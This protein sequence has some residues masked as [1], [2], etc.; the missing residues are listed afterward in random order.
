VG[1]IFAV[2]ITITLTSCGENR[3]PETE[4]IEQARSNYEALESAQLIILDSDLEVIQSFRFKYEGD[5]LTYLLWATDG[6]EVYAEYYN[7]LRLCH[8]KQGDNDWT[9]LTR[10]DN[11]YYTY[12]RISKHPFTQKSLFFFDEASASYIEEDFVVHYN[13]DILN[14][15]SK[16]E[17]VQNL[18][19]TFTIN[20][21]I[22]VYEFNSDINSYT[23]YISDINDVDIIEQPDFS[24]ALA[25]N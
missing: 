23:I 25:M 6:E 9:V 11:G 22:T 21:Y 1:G 18:T 4:P 12:N 8:G 20:E 2:I 15:R 16:N 10:G 5:T 13:T 24:E 7:G 3:F 14:R 19:T 17:P